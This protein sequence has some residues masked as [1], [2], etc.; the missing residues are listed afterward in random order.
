[1]RIKRLGI[2]GTSILILA[3]TVMVS[4]L[5]WAQSGNEKRPLTL[6]E[7]W[8]S[9]QE[10]HPLI[11]AAR[12]R[13]EGADKYRQFAGVRPNPTLTFQSE[14]WRAWGRP[15][16]SFSR[17]I[18]LFIYSTQ[19]FETA[20][21]ATRRRDLAERAFAAVE[22]EVD[23]TRKQLWQDITARYWTA[24]QLQSQ[25]MIAEENRRDLDQL[26]EYTSAR[27]KEGYAAEWEVLRARL[28]QQTLLNQQLVTEQ[29][30]ERAK[31]ELLRAM[32]ATS[33][34]TGFVLLEPALL[35]SPLLRQPVTE[36]LTEAEEKRVELGLLRSRIEAERA[37]LRLQQANARPDLDLS[38]GYKRTVGYN[39]FIAYVTIQL[40][41][42]NK[43]RGEIGQATAG[44][45]SAE[46]ELVARTSYI[47]A[48][49]EVSH[50]AV[51]QLE[52][53]LVEM[54]KD[55]LARADESRNIALTAYR[56][57]AADLYK[58]LEAQRARNEVRRLF[59]RTQLDLQMA[60][61]E[62][63]LA[64]GRRELR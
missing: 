48:E 45:N 58:V 51:R 30:L 46:L 13:V 41:L 35:D 43:N 38:G 1:M 15:P 57:G 50:R 54:K 27:F 21:K 4:Q 2:F 34:N 12:K 64:V 59:Y 32:G 10:S 8:K 42:F 23:L 44:V 28:E 37:N 18:D 52:S 25:L 7:C 11:E 20:G 33:F 6:E 22:I 5:G 29:E 47:K 39:T 26:V 55:F 63:A 62:L 24:L 56:E 16:F 40:P 9:A 31:L 17:E 14:N 36:L 53:R 61:A 19:R 3:S 49:V 60:L